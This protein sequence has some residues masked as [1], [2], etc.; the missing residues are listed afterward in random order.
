MS[1]DRKPH[2]WAEVIHAFADGRAVQ[3]RYC[4]PGGWHNAHTLHGIDDPAF[5]WRIKSEPATLRYRVAL[6]KNGADYYIGMASDPT[7]QHPIEGSPHFVEWR[8]E[9]TTMELPE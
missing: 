2:K 6:F 4:E 1:T 9:W 5:E 7:L 8:T 3:V